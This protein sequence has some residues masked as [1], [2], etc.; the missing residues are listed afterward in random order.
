MN[1]P[2]TTPPDESAAIA[3][4]E[5]ERAAGGDPF[6]LVERLRTLHEAA[7]RRWLGAGPGDLI[8]EVCLAGERGQAAEALRQAVAHLAAAECAQWEIGTWASGA[9]EGLS[10]MREVRDLQLARAWL[11]AV[12]PE[13]SDAA[14]EEARTLLDTVEHDPNRVAA[15]RAR[16]I[17][18]LRA[19]LVAAATG[20]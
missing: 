13:A 8:A 20:R 16:A 19:R 9:G 7:A 1:T 6:V 3:A 5:R 11:L 10:S 2:C 14:L 18:R 15:P 4:A 17:T 12:D